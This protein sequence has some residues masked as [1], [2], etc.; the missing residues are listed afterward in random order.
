MKIDLS[1][2]L[3]L[4]YFEK[5]VMA[6]DFFR[7]KFENGTWNDHDILI[8]YDLQLK[9]EGFDKLDKLIELTSTGDS[10]LYNELKEIKELLK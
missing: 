10:Y 5:E 1:L 9:A 2:E 3:V 4:K 7:S 6:M 8:I